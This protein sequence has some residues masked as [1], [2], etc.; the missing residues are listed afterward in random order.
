MVVPATHGVTM[1][2]HE[3]EGVACGATNEEKEV[4]AHED[5]NLILKT[6]EFGQKTHF[7][8]YL[9]KP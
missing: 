5:L 4:V 6:H 9:I 3:K 2:K 1:A 7:N 8:F